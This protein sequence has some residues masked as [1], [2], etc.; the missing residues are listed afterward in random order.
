MRT[1]RPARSAFVHMPLQTSEQLAAQYDASRTFE[2]APGKTSLRGGQPIALVRSESLT[3]QSEGSFY[4]E[5]GPDRLWGADYC[6]WEDQGQRKW[7][8]TVPYCVLSEWRFG[9]AAIQ[10]LI[11]P[12][13]IAYIICGLIVV[14]IS[15]EPECMLYHPDFV[16][17]QKSLELIYP[18][19]VLQTARRPQSHLTSLSQRQTKTSPPLC[20]SPCQQPTRQS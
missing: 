17:S 6:T 7:R 20:P 14:S 3:S 2:S 8:Q 12:T 18:C 9:G 11:F 19:V 16:H 4:N 1:P 13:A 10:S 15:P 5:F